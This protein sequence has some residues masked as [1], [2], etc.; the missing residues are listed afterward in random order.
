LLNSEKSASV[1]Y[2][3][4][5]FGGHLICDQS[6]S[7]GYE[8]SVRRHICGKATKSAGGRLREDLDI[9]T[10]CTKFQSA[11]GRLRGPS[12]CEGATSRP[13]VGYDKKRASAKS[14][15]LQSAGGRLR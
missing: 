9:E 14:A 11:G 2:E 7:A 10:R 15:E 1:G 6:A 12:V 13:V 3:N 5:C 4:N 8:K